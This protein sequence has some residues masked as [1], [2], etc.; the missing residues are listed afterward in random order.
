MVIMS[1]IV[2]M[3]PLKAAIMVVSGFARF[4][5]SLHRGEACVLKFHGLRAD[6][7]EDFLGTGLH[8]LASTFREVCAHFARHCEVRHL[9][10]IVSALQDGQAIAEGTVALTFDGGY[11]SNYDLAFP[12]LREFG[13][14]ATIFPVTAFLDKAEMPWFIRIEFALAHSP[15]EAMVAEVGSQRMALRL[16]TAAD[17][18][19]SLNALKKALMTMPQEE[20]CAQVDQLENDLEA[21]LRNESELPD[22]HRPLS[23]D[24]VRE[25]QN[26]GL[27]EFGGHTHQHL[28]LSRCQ[29]H[30]A[31]EEIATCRNRLKQ[32]TRLAPQLFAYPEGQNEDHTAETSRMLR[33][34]G[35]RS[36][37]TSSPGFVGRDSDLLTLPRCGTPLSNYDAE[38]TVSGVFDT[39]KRWRSRGIQLL[40]HLQ[41]S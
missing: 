10:E 4:T 20:I 13:L 40:S 2:T 26:S 30:T 17:R 27:V 41:P 18:R 33:E 23:W 3:R 21:R 11:A 16:H 24:Q 7:D 37:V 34:A 5:R 38:A 15:R 35:F 28:I 36:A 12:V 8:T 6:G 14:P 9:T 31:W 32:E 29:P 39:I 25:M 1:N 19:T 22:S